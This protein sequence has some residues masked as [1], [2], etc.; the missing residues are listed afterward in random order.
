M[1]TTPDEKIN[2]VS[3]D[4]I[5]K[6]SGLSIPYTFVVEIYHV[7]TEPGNKKPDVRLGSAVTN[8]TG[9]FVVEFT[10]ETFK[11]SAGVIAAQLRP[12]IKLTVSKPESSDMTLLGNIIF[13]S[14]LRS[15]A[16][17][18]EN[19]RIE[20]SSAN[21]QK[22]GIPIP[23]TEVVIP[24]A[25]KIAAYQKEQDEAF[26]LTTGFLEIDRK[27]QNTFKQ[28][29]KDYNKKVEEEEKAGKDE[30]RKLIKE[31]ILPDI[32]IQENMYNFVKSSD[33]IE[34]IQNNVYKV[35]TEYIDKVIATVGTNPVPG[36][37]IRVNLIL[38]PQEK[39]LLGS[40]KFTYNGKDYFNIPENIIQELLFKREKDE[41][42]NTI[43]FSN[44]PISKFC[45]LI[46]A[47]KS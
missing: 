35:G 11:N 38:T 37:G 28:D 1:P 39:E 44:N 41:G 29:L 4:I 19:Y 26:K 5:H 15:N 10:D 2:R 47:T 8:Q 27:M 21:L 45:I 3:G 30:L 36:K 31:A 32:K 13:N 24:T 9:G 23:T 25:Q 20:L 40:F 34:V 33:S 18:N 6:E 17:S 7:F 22:A 42:I 43:L 12:N 14:N 46:T 16:V